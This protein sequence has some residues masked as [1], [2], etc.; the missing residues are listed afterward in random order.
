ME[1]NARKLQDHLNSILNE[2]GSP[3][4]WTQEDA[5]QFYVKFCDPQL[6]SS[7]LILEIISVRELKNNN[8]L[9]KAAVLNRDT[10]TPFIL[11]F[12]NDKW[13]VSFIVQKNG[14]EYKRGEIL[15]ALAEELKFNELP[16][17][18]DKRERRKL[19]M[20]FINVNSIQRASFET[21][22]MA[23]FGEEIV[24]RIAERLGPLEKI[25]PLIV[26][27]LQ[28]QIK[29][30][31]LILEAEL[32]QRRNELLANLREQEMKLQEEYRWKEEQF[33]KEKSKLDQKLKRL[34]GQKKL[35]SDEESLLDKR[36]QEIEEQ[37]E[38]LS[39][40]AQRLEEYKRSLKSQFERFRLVHPLLGDEDNA[41]SNDQTIHWSDQEDIIATIQG[42]LHAQCNLQY[43][44]DIIECFIGALKTNQLIILHGPSGTGK[45]SLARGF[46]K[47]IKG[48]KTY[49]I[50][51]QSSWTD[52][53]D[54]LGFFNP[55]DYQYVST[56]FLDAL[57]EAK[58]NPKSLYLICLDEMNLSHVEYYF[59]EFLS[60]REEENPKITLYSRQFQKQAYKMIESYITVD[61][62]GQEVLDEQKLG[63]IKNDSE[64]WR[65][66]NCFDLCHRYPAEFEIPSNVRF[67]GTMNMD[68]TVKGLSPKVIDRS[69]VIN[70]RYPENEKSLIEE[71]EKI[72][73]SELISVDLEKDLTVTVMDEDCRQ[74]AE[75]I[76]PMLDKLGG[77]LNRRALDQIGYYGS[78]VNSHLKFDQIV[79]G[80]ILPRIQVSR[81]DETVEALK[82]L[83]Q[84][85]KNQSNISPLTENKIE[86]M[87][88]QGRTITYWR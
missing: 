48:A 61:D 37:K 52:K 1:N 15:T 17:E 36:K 71:L 56:E 49:T 5:H 67:V 82:Q 81:N 30:E 68:H 73:V 76:N 35:I 85:L 69:F 78:A 8:L 25:A 43:E 28:S 66:Q 45:S 33:D 58:K 12:S 6:L 63:Q 27:H 19:G 23:H 24:K 2:L 44:R 9:L 86:E 16:D 87:L 72:K 13:V 18:K 50:R 3:I 70:L 46:S 80:K 62:K 39:K 88:K 14:P 79:R 54:I 31:I 32:N 57:V 21:S 55:I 51:V 10:L 22:L 7:R 42:A 41:I 75:E 83:L 11:P 53:Q 65:L 84:K 60:A 38:A 74:K 4:N 77:R 64:R 59:A 20:I 26:S 34:E 47:I 40:E 29:D